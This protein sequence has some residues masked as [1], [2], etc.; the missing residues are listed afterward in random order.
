MELLS[1]FKDFAQSA[2]KQENPVDNFIVIDGAFGCATCFE[3]VDQAR[4]YP[5]DRV[6][7]WRCSETHVSSIED[8][9][10]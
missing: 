3:Q 5:D 6:L 4:Y 1:N 10:L 8:F 9:I 2:R 7:A